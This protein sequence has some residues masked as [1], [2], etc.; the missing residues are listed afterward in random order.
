MNCRLIWV[1]EFAVSDLADYFFD[2][3]GAES[4]K[5]FSW[6]YHRC[7]ALPPTWCREPLCLKKAI[8]TPFADS[9]R[10]FVF[11]ETAFC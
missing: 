10:L 3:G 2:S 1:A 9:W 6:R 8:G 5:K 4:Q 11:V 7:S